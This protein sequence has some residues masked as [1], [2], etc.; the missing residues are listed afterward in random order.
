MELKYKLVK[1]QREKEQAERR[2]AEAEREIRKQEVELMRGLPVSEGRPCNV[3]ILPDGTIAV[4]VWVESS[5][6][7]NQLHLVEPLFVSEY[8]RER[9]SSVGNDWGG[10]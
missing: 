3:G 7:P 2:I 10:R 1:A 9:K 5:S 4:H 6:S 8:G